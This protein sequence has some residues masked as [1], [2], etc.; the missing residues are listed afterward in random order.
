MSPSAISTIVI[1]AFFVCLVIGLV[2]GFFKGAIKSAVDLGGVLL[3][4]I[5]ALPITKGLTA[6]LVSSNALNAIASKLLEMLPNEAGAYVETVKS[7]LADETTK[8]FVTDIIELIVSLPTI[9]LSP[10]VFILV[11]LILGAIFG[12]V[13]TILKLLVC[14]KTKGLGWRI[15]GS[16]VGAFTYVVTFAIILIPVTG[17]SNFVGDTSAHIIE[18]IEANEQNEKEEPKKEIPSDTEGDTVA[19]LSEELEENDDMSS[20]EADGEENSETTE[21]KKKLDIKPV[22]NSIIEYTT[23]LQENFVSKTVYILGGKGIFNSLTTNRVDGMEIALQAEVNGI[24]DLCDSALK[25]VDVQPKNYSSEQSEALNNINESLESSEY[26]PLLLS[27][28]ISFVSTEYYK[29]NDVFGI[30][31]PDLGEDFNPTLD[32]V[33]LVLMDTDSNDIRK[34]IKTISN[35]ANGALETGIIGEVTSEEIDV[36]K[37]VEN[38]D[39]IEIILVELYK[40]TRTRNAIPYVTS[41]LTNYIY[42][43]YN[44]INETAKDPGKF[45]YSHYNEAQL[46]VEAAYIAGAVREIHSFLANTDLGENFDPKDVI[47]N[48]DMSALGR[49]LENLREGVFTERAF[50]IL[51]HAILRSEAITETGIVDSVLITS[52]EKENADLEGMLVARQNI[53]K[54]AI[55]IQEKQ[56]KEQTKELMDS[57]IESI[58][59]GEDESLGSIVNKDNLTSL[60]MKEKDAESIEGIVGSMLDGANDCEFET[61]EEKTVEIEKTEE[62]ISAVGNTVLDKTEDNMFKTEDNETST[63]DMTAQDFVDSVLD[64]KLTSSMVQN[65]SKDENG[66][67]VNDPYKI[68]K[69]LSDTDKVEISQAINNTYTNEDLTDEERAT[70]ESLANIFGVIIEK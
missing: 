44:D 32:K 16:V 62:I 8:G 31:K 61:E 7:Y 9:L 23:P 40:N 52:A 14:P 51:L 6:L 65:A 22:L 24:V 15:L 41:A 30:E 54:L 5:L 63:T 43:M 53:M 46:T 20:S 56:D 29:G 18:V 50:E 55:V 26:L 60:G 42:E 57:V 19:T 3:S 12:I 68:Q 11:F 66:E 25:F 48:S 58:I 47:M 70:L 1:V 10:I 67:T 17:Y 4:A 38:E 39:M 13:A 59:S 28:V 34:D 35:I 49:G 27:K 69:E 64:S 36:W 45:D 37:I 2:R 33:L 21:D